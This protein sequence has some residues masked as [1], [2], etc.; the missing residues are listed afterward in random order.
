MASGTLTID[1]DALV[2]NW[3]ALAKAPE[4]GAVVKADAYGLGLAPVAH[5]LAKAGARS[6]I[7]RHKHIVFVEFH[8]WIYS[9]LARGL[10]QVKSGRSKLV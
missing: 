2:H 3:R 8:L 7:V 10:T 9:V 1:L 6:G 4:T 5:A